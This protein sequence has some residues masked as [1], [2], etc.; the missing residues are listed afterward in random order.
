MARG[1]RLAPEEEEAARVVAAALDVGW[2]PWDVR[3]RAPGSYDIRLHLPGGRLGAL[4]V[5]SLT[6]PKIDR[7]LAALEEHDGTWAA[8]RRWAWTV[9]ANGVDLRELEPIFR[10]VALR[11]ESAGLAGPDDFHGEAARTDDA[12]YLRR[13]RVHMR[14]QAC[15]GAPPA[16]RL[17]PGWQAL[18]GGADTFVADLAAAFAAS[19]ANLVKH[20]AKLED[21]PEDQKHLYL[22]ARSAAFPTTAF[23]SERTEMPVERPPIPEHITHLWLHP[24]DLG[25]RVLWWADGLWREYP[26]PGH[27]G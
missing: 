24:R 13:N 1:D 15:D 5:T 26:P 22:F 25:R 12:R 3:D 4:E 17:S 7:D 8:P 14:G 20:F 2:E 19:Q 21:G 11:C 6:L 10:R 18:N 27:A 9:R 23:L 16:V